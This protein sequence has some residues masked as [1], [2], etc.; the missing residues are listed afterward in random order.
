LST[1]RIRRGLERAPSVSGE[2][3][4]EMTEEKFSK[5]KEL[6]ASQN[7][8]L[9]K[10]AILEGLLS[11]SSVNITTPNNCNFIYS[12]SKQQLKAIVNELIGYHN[13]RIKQLGDEFDAL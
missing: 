9:S 8:E 2:E 6:K 12:L 3:G 7:T 4:S 10:I 5:A 13:T 11:C 1:K